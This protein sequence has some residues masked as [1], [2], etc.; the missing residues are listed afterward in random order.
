M[1]CVTTVS[2]VD[3]AGFCWLILKAFFWSSLLGGGRE[4]E[5]GEGDDVIKVCYS[6]GTGARAGMHIARCSVGR[7]QSLEGTTIVLRVE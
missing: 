3:V 6:T 4:V 2:V 5:Q 1:W 7:K